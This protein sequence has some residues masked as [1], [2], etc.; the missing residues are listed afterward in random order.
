VI[1]NIEFKVIILDNETWDTIFTSDP[2]MLTTIGSEGYT[3]V[4]DKFDNVALEEQG[5]KISLGKPTESDYYGG[6]VIPV[7]VENNSG[8]TVNVSLS[9]T[10]V[11][12]YMMDFY[13]YSTIAD[14]K[15]SYDIISFYQSELDDNNIDEINEI[16]FKVY[17]YEA[18]N[19]EYMIESDSISVSFK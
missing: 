11:N 15:L 3:Q 1:K 18:D 10:S 5:I 4:F 2:I 7:I 14:G 16:E 12:D 19:W 17:V 8:K 13:F 6:M 9:D